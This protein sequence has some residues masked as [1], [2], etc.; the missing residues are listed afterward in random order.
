MAAPKFEVAAECGVDGLAW[1]RTS[2]LT[3]SLCPGGLM[4]CQSE[5]ERL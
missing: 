5:V 4:S 3:V 2:A 1:F